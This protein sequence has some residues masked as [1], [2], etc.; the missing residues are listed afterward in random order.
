[1]ILVF[2]FFTRK[3]GIKNVFLDI[4]TRIMQQNKQ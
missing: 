3:I 4:G 2:L 1:M